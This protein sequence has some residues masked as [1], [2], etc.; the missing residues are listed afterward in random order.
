M[1]PCYLTPTTSIARAAEGGRP[2]PVLIGVDPVGAGLAP[3]LV[4][5]AKHGASG[6]PSSAR[7]AGFIKIL[8]EK[9]KNMPEQKSKHR[10]YAEKKASTLFR[11]VASAIEKSAINRESVNAYNNNIGDSGPNVNGKDKNF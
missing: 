1:P 7:R 2:Y 11:T 9:D 3:A 4:Q 6:G 10:V 5:S 8:F